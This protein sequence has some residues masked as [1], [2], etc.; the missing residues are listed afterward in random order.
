MSRLS[1]STQTRPAAASAHNGRA[2]GNSNGT[3]AAEGKGKGKA[4]APENGTE[5][6]ES[7]VQR[8]QMPLFEM[9]SQFK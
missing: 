6:G 3:Q 1:A 8:G 9:S 5:N 4:T 7:Q 2:S